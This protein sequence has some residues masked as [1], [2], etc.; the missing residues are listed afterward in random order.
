MLSLL[1]YK[2]SD[3]CR[4]FYCNYTHVFTGKLEC[5]ATTA[6]HCQYKIVAKEMFCMWLLVS[7]VRNILWSNVLTSASCVGWPYHFS[8]HLEIKLEKELIKYE[9]NTT[10]HYSYWMNIKQVNCTFNARVAINH[11][12]ARKTGSFH[13]TKRQWRSRCLIH[14]LSACLLWPWSK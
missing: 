5:F 11:L 4:Y 13:R 8:Q 7:C 12:Q 1:Q 10:Y 3:I 9:V 14:M 2:K 6:S